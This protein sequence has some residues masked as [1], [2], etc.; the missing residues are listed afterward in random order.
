MLEDQEPA[1][2]PQSQDR[3]CGLFLRVWASL[4]LQA[5]WQ[6]SSS[7]G[8][9][10]TSPRLARCYGRL[11]PVRIFV[12][13]RAIGAVYVGGVNGKAAELTEIDR[14]T[15]KPLWTGAVSGG[16]INAA[17]TVNN[18]IV[19]ASNDSSVYAFKAD[20]GGL[21]WVR[22]LGGDLDGRPTVADGMVFVTSFANTVYAIDAVDG[23]LL[24]EYAAG[25]V[26]TTTGSLIQ[27]SITVAG[28]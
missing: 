26:P 24:W 13:N 23:S 7:P 17:P 5:S 3:G 10:P 18:G 8:N 14:F 9:H 27:P 2:V 1:R 11:I 4:L 25:A 15:G 19:Y 22:S 16:A 6:P 28:E 21:R 20:D 12:A